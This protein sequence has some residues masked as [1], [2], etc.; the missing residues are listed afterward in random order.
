MSPYA[1][2]AIVVLWGGSVGGAYFYGSGVGKDGEIANQ[3]KINQAITDT[4]EAAQL[5]AADAIA[6]IKVTNTT[7]KGRIETTIRD[8]PIYV[9]CKHGDDGL[10]DINEALTGKSQPASGSKLPRADPVDQF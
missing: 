2:L 9:D 3:A 4:R 10:R 8:N 5:G 6:K 1:I 7:I